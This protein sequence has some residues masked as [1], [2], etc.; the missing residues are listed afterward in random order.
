MA[1]KSR[2]V[3]DRGTLILHPPPRGK[4]WIEWATWDERIEK[5]RIPG[6]CY[7]PLIE[8]LQEEGIEIVDEAKA[9]FSLP[10]QFSPG[11]T[12]FPHQKEALAA[13]GKAGGRGVVVLPTGGGKTF[14]A[15]L[16][17]AHVATTTLIVVPTLDLMHQWY[18]E[19]KENIKGAEVGLLGGGS[20]DYSPILIAT[21]HSAS[22]HSVVLGNCYGLLI[23]DECHHLPTDFFRNIAEDSIAPYRLGLTATPERTDGNHKELER[24]VGKIVYRKTP[25]QLSGKTLAEYEVVT[26]KVRLSDEEKQCYHQA[27][28]V[29]NEFLKRHNIPLRNLEGWQMFVKISSSSVEGR[30]AMLAHRMAKEIALGTEAKIR[31]LAELL[32]RHYPDKILIFTHDNATVYLISQRF[33]IP[34]ITHQTPVKERHEILTAYRQGTYKIVV[35]SHVLNE[36]IDVPSAKIAIILS[37]TG[38]TREYT[39]RLG[40][41]L[42]R[43]NHEQK[44]AILYEIIAENTLEEITSARRKEGLDFSASPPTFK[45]AESPCRWP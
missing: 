19:I 15:H 3:Y 22:V 23:F 27:I 11:K 2:L 5:F 42:R 34:A 17:M 38:S 24:L 6:Y 16:A 36:G 8:S 44:L 29:R 39:Q 41:I 25:K 21:Y 20:R 45:A 1:K 13:W 35:A 37:G 43:D 30:R 31:V 10:L 9:Y 18:G 4:K 28:K 26:I 7:R 12:P 32:A 14:L 33:L 40:R